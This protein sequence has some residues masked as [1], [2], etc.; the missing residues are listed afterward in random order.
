MHP[1]VSHVICLAF[2]VAVG[3]LAFYAS[4]C[5]GADEGGQE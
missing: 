3:A 4:T 2:G 5:G 1:M